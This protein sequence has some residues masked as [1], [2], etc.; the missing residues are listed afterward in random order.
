MQISLKALVNGSYVTL[1]PPSFTNLK[2]A[3]DSSGEDAARF[4]LINQDGGLVALRS[5][6]T[7]KYVCAQDAGKAPLVCDRDEVGDWEHFELINL[8]NEQVALR[9]Q[10]NGKAVCCEDQGRG[11]LIANRDSVGDWE[12]F[13]MERHYPADELVHQLDFV[14]TMGDDDLRGGGDNLDLA[15]VTAQGRVLPYP[16]INGNGA[17]AAHTYPRAYVVLTE[18]MPAEQITA[19]ILIKTSGSGFSID[20]CDLAAIS[21]KSGGRQIATAGPARLTGSNPWFIIP[22]GSTTRLRMVFATGDDDLRGGNDNV[23]VLV[24]FSD[25]PSRMFDNVNQ[26]MRWPDQ[27]VHEVNLDLGAGVEIDTVTTLT[28]IT[29]FAGG[30]SGDNWKMDWLKVTASKGD[31][32]KEVF[33]CGY[34]YFTGDDKRIVL[35]RSDRS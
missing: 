31:V 17:W 10:I 18:P 24:E 16:N 23:H 2:A 35:N 30:W 6:K 9:A 21:V 34:H 25:R 1:T 28:V 22:I 33:V 5:T 27:S 29:N 12:T 14:I 15:I 7:G 26:T 32:E 11:F 8:L 4:E 20:N 3:G 13:R 19:L